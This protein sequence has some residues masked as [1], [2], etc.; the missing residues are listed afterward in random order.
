MSGGI[1]ELVALGAQDEF[2]TANPQVSFFRSTFKRYTNFSHF[3]KR[4]QIVGTPAPGGMSQIRF[5]RKGDLLN[6]TFLTLEKDGVS[7]LVSEWSNVIDSVELLIGGQ[8]IDTQDA[9]FTQEIAIDTLASTYSKSFPASLA[10]GVG[11]QSYF[12]PFRF[13]FCENWV[14]SLPLIALQYH[15]VEL[16]IRWG[17]NYDT[18]WSPRVH[19]MYI[20]LDEDERRFFTEN[21]HDMLITQVQKSVPSQ[22]PIQELNF[23][24]PMKF[25][26]SSNTSTNSL[27][28]KGNRVKL[29][30]NGVDLTDFN[31]CVPY[32]TAVPSYYHTDFSSGNQTNLFL[33][34]FCM[35]TA[36]NQPTGSLNFSR[37]DNF[38]IHCS[39]P[40]TEPV[41]GVNV[42]VLRIQN[43]LGG[44]M[45][46]N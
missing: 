21:S 29:E 45:F 23:N 19:S 5:E 1:V 8:V 3:E 31:L 28:S 27:V 10:S 32:Y 16:R 24:H 26:A 14:S 13:F 40:V 6:Y 7:N 20:A 4:Q 9:K 41:Y 11:S 12:Y 35:N 30:A 22:E 18:T 43:G 38:K 34:S 42:N 17:A 39:E 15:D 37:L 25:I 46:A 44:L 33:Y 36:Q 2:L